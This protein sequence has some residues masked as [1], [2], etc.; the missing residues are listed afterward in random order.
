LPD[1]LFSNQES[2]FW[3][4]LEVFAIKDAGVFYGQLVNYRA[5]W[6]ILWQFGIFFWLFG[7]FFPVLVYCTTKN[8]A[9]KL[10]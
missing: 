10:S 3:S 7:I 8:L 5:I 1:G 9:T 4:I 2:Q 6:C